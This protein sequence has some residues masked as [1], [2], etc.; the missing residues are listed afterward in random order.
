MQNIARGADIM[1]CDAELAPYRVGYPIESAT[2]SSRLPYRVGYPIESATLSN[3]LPYRVGCFKSYIEM[4][5][6]VRALIEGESEKL[7]VF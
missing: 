5:V 3:R 4:L 7:R 1:Q 6:Y 2:L